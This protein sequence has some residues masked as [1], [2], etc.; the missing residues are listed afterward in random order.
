MNR[1]FGHGWLDNSRESVFVS[2]SIAEDGAET[3]ECYYNLSDCK[4]NRDWPKRRPVSL[5]ADL[6]AK[7]VSAKEKAIAEARGRREYAAAR[8]KGAPGGQVRIRFRRDM[9]TR[10]RD[11]V[12]G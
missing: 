4:G 7:L 10:R 9:G 1:Y 11:G 12:H 8:R 6:W 5:P 3:V 2:L